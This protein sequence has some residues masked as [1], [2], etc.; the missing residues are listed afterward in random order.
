MHVAIE[1]ETGFVVDAGDTNT[2]KI[3]NLKK[4]F[5]E[6]YDCFEIEDDE[7]VR[8]NFRN[9]IVNDTGDGV[10]YSEERVGQNVIH[11]RNNMLI[12]IR[13]IRDVKLKESD[14]VTLSDVTMDEELKQKWLVY[15]QELRDWT[16][17]HNIEVDWRDDI[18]IPP[19][20]NRETYMP[21]TF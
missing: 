18:P 16:S 21:G 8:N 3:V 5:P 6:I 1:L 19:G 4:H 11:R 13:R 10:I 9:Y 7:N 2:E 15:R 14:W 12:K 17:T 20:E